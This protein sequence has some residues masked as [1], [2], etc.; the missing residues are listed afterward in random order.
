[1]PRYGIRSYR[2][3]ANIDSG[4]AAVAIIAEAEARLAQ[5]GRPKPQIMSPVPAT[6]GWMPSRW[7]SVLFDT[8]AARSM[9]KRR[10]LEGRIILDIGPAGIWRLENFLL[11]KAMIAG[12]KVRH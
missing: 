12:A 11:A 8:F 2:T 3:K 6:D 7:L 1:M 4:R 10:E 9:Q 5:A